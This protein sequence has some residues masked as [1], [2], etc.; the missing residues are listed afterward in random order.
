MTIPPIGRPGREG[1]PAEKYRSTLSESLCTCR[2]KKRSGMPR[3]SDV[4]SA[5]TRSDPPAEPLCPKEL[6]LWSLM[7]LRSSAKRAHCPHGFPFSDPRKEHPME[8]N[9]LNE[10]AALQRLSRSGMTW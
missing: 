1:S 9:I 2:A 10:V 3:Q 5:L 6:S 7:A 4:K 8:L